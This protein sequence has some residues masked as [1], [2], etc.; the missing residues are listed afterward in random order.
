MLHSLF[1]KSSIAFLVAALLAV[2]VVQVQTVFA[3][4]TYGADEA[5]T[6]SGFLGKKIEGAR[7]LV[8]LIVDQ[9][10]WNDSTSY[11]G[12]S[13]SKDNGSGFLGLGGVSSGDLRG[14]VERYAEDVQKALPKTQV[15]I[16]PVSQEPQTVLKVQQVLERLYQEGDPD[17]SSPTQLKGVVMVGEVPSGRSKGG[18]FS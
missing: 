15:L 2:N 7:D 18:Q 5:K 8:A 12:L 14:R 1:K 16:L 9:E 4:A 10:V 17:N 3:E 13:K 6:T 11:D